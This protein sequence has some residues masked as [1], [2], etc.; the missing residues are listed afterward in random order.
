MEEEES[1]NKDYRSSS[2]KPTKG[3]N[4]VKNI[5]ADSS[6][7]TLGVRRQGEHL[8]LFFCL[9][10]NLTTQVK[11]GTMYLYLQNE[12]HQLEAQK[13]AILTGL[14]QLLHYCWWAMFPFHPMSGTYPCSEVIF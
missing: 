2:R 6:L 12:N 7:L 5:F 11:R 14:Y 8:H 4:L 3:K 10:L 9:F 13:K 1:S